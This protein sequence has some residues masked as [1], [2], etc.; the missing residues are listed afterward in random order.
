MISVAI[1]FEALCLN[2]QAEGPNQGLPEH[3]EDTLQGVAVQAG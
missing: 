2:P 1:R 3:P